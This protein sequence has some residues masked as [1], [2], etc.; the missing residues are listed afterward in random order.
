MPDHEHEIPYVR[1]ARASHNH[2]LWTEKRRFSRWEAWEDLIWEARY[3]EEPVDVHIDGH[4]VTI[5][6]GMSFR[7]LRTWAERWNWNASSVSR[8]FDKLRKEKMIATKRAGKCRVIT[9]LNYATYNPIPTTRART[10]QE[11]CNNLATNVQASCNDSAT[12]LQPE[13]ERKKEQER[14]NQTAPAGARVCEE[15]QTSD[16]SLSGLETLASDPVTAS[17]TV[18]SAAFADTW[19]EINAAQLS[20]IETE[21]AKLFAHRAAADGITHQDQIE[22]L[23]WLQTSH[24]QAGVPRLRKPQ[25]LLAHADGPGGWYRSLRDARRRHTATATDTATAPNASKDF[26]KGW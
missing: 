9:I 8:F 18:V 2:W 25:L 14:E 26:A 22:L 7:D 24:G 5:S 20:H 16:P 17:D 6:R 15:P 10:L 4:I 23:E 11:S 1:M 12:I 19:H 3:S 13:E 21:Q